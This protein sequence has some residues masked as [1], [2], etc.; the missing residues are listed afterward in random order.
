MRY[1]VVFELAGPLAGAAAVEWTDAAAPQGSGSGW[2]PCLRLADGRWRLSQPRSRASAALAR[3][4][5]LR[6]H[7]HPLSPDRR[8]P[9]VAGLGQPQGDRHRRR[10]PGGRASRRRGGGLVGARSRSSSATG[11]F[12]AA[13]ALAGGPAAAVAVDWT[14]AP[15]PAEADWR[16]C[17]ALGAGALAA[18]RRRQ[19]GRG[20]R[21][22]RRHRHPLPPDGGG[23]GLGGLRRP[24]ELRGAD[25]DPAGPAGGAGARR[26]RQDR[27]GARAST[28]ASGAARPCPRSPCSGCRDG[29]AIPGATG[30]TYLPGP[31]DDLTELAARVTATSVAG[32]LQAETATVR[33]THVAPVAVGEL[34]DEVFDEDTGPQQLAAAAAFAGANLRF[35]VTGAG[36]SIDPATGLVSIPTAAPVDGAQVTVTASNSGGSA[37]LSFLVTV[38]AAALP[39][40]PGACP[41]AVWTAVEVTET[42]RRPATS[43]AAARPRSARPRSCPPASRCTSTWAA[44]R[45]PRRAPASRRSRPAATV[46]T[47]TAL[48]V[49]ATC[50]PRLYWRR[51]ADDLFQA[52]GE[53]PPFAIRGSSSRRRAA[54]RAMPQAMV[55]DALGRRADRLRRLSAARQQL[56]LLRRGAAAAGGQQLR[57]RHRAR[58]RGCCRTCATTSRPGTIPPA[59]GGFTA[60]LELNFA[61]AAA[62]AR[63]TPRV[64]DQLTAAER[65]RID[66]AMKG[67]LVANAFTSSDTNPYFT[68]KTNPQKNL[69]GGTAWRTGNPNF[70]C[71][72]PASG[73]RGAGVSRLERG[74]HGVPRRL[75]HGG[76][77]DAG[78]EQQSAQHATRPTAPHRPPTAEPRRRCRRR[79]GTGR[80]NGRSSPTSPASSSTRRTSPPAGP[81][82][83][84]TTTG[85]DS[86]TAGAA[87]S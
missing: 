23:A 76:L 82:R 35:A 5:A 3:S 43:P 20:Q 59:T 80:H 2:E 1:T 71:A 51:L 39:D 48:A 13:F 31:A 12:T 24:Q 17:V 22:D 7:R 27:A 41:P 84:A 78:A 49:G 32:S 60:Q 9:L 57:G 69:R 25:P 63:L 77:R 85:P 79:S 10:D 86:V 44:A 65:T 6:Q 67:Q 70:R 29:A 53:K 81:S 74:G 66:I 61:V 37:A 62:I 21:R 4:R 18:R 75:R 11:V 8:R 54:S 52:A 72:A 83:P 55:D 45:T 34:F 64:W 30:A 15:A 87:R 47:D 16:P 14:V 33:I 73:A 38:E 56:G 58:T 36:A 42:R 26:H 50:R 28:P 46:I 19:H 40:F 68:P